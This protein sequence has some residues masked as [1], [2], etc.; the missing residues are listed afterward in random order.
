MGEEKA[1]ERKTA[2]YTVHSGEGMKKD[3]KRRK[4]NERMRAFKICIGLH[5]VWTIS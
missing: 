2:T 4:E 3:I 5:K 1:S